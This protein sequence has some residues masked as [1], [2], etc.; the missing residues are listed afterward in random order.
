M[1]DGKESG[2]G[3]QTDTTKQD[4][5]A[6]NETQKDVKQDEESS[7]DQQNSVKESS[8][9]QSQNGSSN[10]GSNNENKQEETPASVE[11]QYYTV[12]KGD[13]LYSISKLVYGDINMID[14]IREANHMSDTDENITI[15]QRLLLP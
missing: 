3:T 7:T 15:G 11:P 12:K 6:E 14:K 5:N 10:D 8:D 9:N 13:S 2:D 4:K 1:N